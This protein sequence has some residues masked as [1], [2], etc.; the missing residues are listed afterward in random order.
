MGSCPRKI[1]KWFVAKAL[2][3]VLLQVVRKLVY[4]A[5][6]AASTL[7]ATPSPPWLTVCH[8]NMQACCLALS[9]V[10]GEYL[11][12]HKRQQGT[13]VGRVTQKKHL[14]LLPGTICGKPPPCSGRKRK[15]EHARLVN[16]EGG[17][18]LHLVCNE[19]RQNRTDIALETA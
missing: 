18:L 1:E 17:W 19:R 13:T 14:K 6:H 10:S 5:Q 7:G 2:S 3:Y 15:T 8:L 12:A 4:S 9:L 11:T 16:L